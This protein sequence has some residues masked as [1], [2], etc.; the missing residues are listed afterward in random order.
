MPAARRR[1]TRVRHEVRCARVQEQS[2]VG[3]ARRHAVTRECA[4][5]RCPR[6]RYEETS[7]PVSTASFASAALL[8]SG[9]TSSAVR[10]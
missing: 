1:N 9:A 10:T 6:T 3:A 5:P 7:A 4:P 2:R 8:A